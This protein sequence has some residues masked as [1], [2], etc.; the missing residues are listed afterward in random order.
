MG[1]AE[2]KRDESLHMSERRRIESAKPEREKENRG[3][4]DFS[5]VDTGGRKT[6]SKSYTVNSMPQRSTESYGNHALPSQDG[7]QFTHYKSKR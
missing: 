5:M 7:W 1:S 4:G 6:I 2:R 3:G